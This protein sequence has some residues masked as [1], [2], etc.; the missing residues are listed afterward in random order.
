MT[1]QTVLMLPSV[2][3]CQF[4]RGNLCRVESRVRAGDTLQVSLQWLRQPSQATAMTSEDA[5]T[6]EVPEAQTHKMVTASELD[7]GMHHVGSLCKYKSSVW[8]HALAT[9]I[10]FECL[11]FSTG[12]ILKCTELH[13]M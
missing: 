8:T 9:A 7:S 13:T 2:S 6:L 1:K 4:L 12:K 11:S 10:L 5:R 3:M